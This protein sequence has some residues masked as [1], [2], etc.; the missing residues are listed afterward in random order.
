MKICEISRC[1]GCAA[2]CNICGKKAIAMQPDK[3]GFLRPVIDETKC[4][5]CGK[6]SKICPVANP[7]L[8][9][10][11]Q[12]KTFAAYNQNEEERLASSSGGIFTLFAKYVLENG[13]AVFGAV[14]DEQFRVKH[15]SVQSE[16]ELDKLRG[17]KYLQSEIGKTYSEA[18]QLLQ[19]G[20]MVLFTGTPCQ[21][22]GLLSFLGKDYDNLYTQD[23]ICHGVPSPLVWEKYVKYREKIASSAVQRAFFRNKKYGWKRYS[24]SFEF[25]NDTEYLQTMSEDLYMKSFLRNLSL[26]PSCYDCQFKKLN[27]LS[28]ITVADF[29]GIQNIAPEMDDDKGISLVI[30]HSEK[31]QKL[32]ESVQALIVKKD[33]DLLDAIKDNSPMTTSVSV[34]LNRNKFMKV[35]KYKRFDKCVERYVDSKPKP[36]YHYLPQ[37]CLRRLLGD[38][39]VNKLKSVVKR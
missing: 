39:F 29:W 31:G 17:S 37:R 38:T 5:S 23:L 7:K 8:E 14:F 30:V 25:S 10:A 6:C 36:D 27:R 32:W 1:T 4:V 12:P 13:G 26:R 28:D 22:E 21:I 19:Q 24:V 18:K 35:V 16:D 15:I 9:Q 2:C 11:G 34:P 20:R 33:V 3:D